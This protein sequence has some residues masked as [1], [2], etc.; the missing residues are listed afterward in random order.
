MYSIED[1]D[2]ICLASQALRLDGASANCLTLSQLLGIV[3]TCPDL[4]QLA[5]LG[6]RAIPE[7]GLSDA[8]TQLQQLQVGASING[9]HEHA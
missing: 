3:H 4:K 5:L 9:N 7:K 6:V 8:L 2:T 1:F